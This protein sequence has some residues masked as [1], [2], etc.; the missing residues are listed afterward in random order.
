MAK[1]KIKTV[2]DEILEVAD[3]KINGT[4]PWDAQ[5]NNDASYSRVIKDGS[6]GLG[7]SFMEGWWDTKALDQLLYKV[8]SANLEQKILNNKK[9]LLQLFYE[10]FFNRQSKSKAFEVG[11]QHYDLGNDLYEAMLDKRMV[12]TCGYWKNAKNLDEAQEDK[13]DL[14]CRKLQLKKGMKV[15]DIGFGFGSFAKYAAQKYGVSVDGV[16]VSK[17]QL[18]YAQ[19]YCKGL[20]INLELKDYRDIEGKYDRIVSIGMFEA[21]GHKNFRTYM[22]VVHDHLT[23]DGLTLLHTIGTMDRKNVKDPWID[24]Y[25]FVNGELPNMFHVTNSI[26]KLFVM[27][28]WH[29]FGAYYDLT[30]M[31]WHKNFEKNWSKLSGKYDE[32]FHRMWNFYLL[33]CAA[34]FRAR[35]TQLWQIVL[36]KKGVKGGYES[37]R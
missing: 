21:V 2:I 13:L 36:S 28:D 17:E 37:I 34:L 27:E 3:I 4:R 22:K 5:V 12:Y 18:K 29:N 9:L 1:Q 31:A 10:K 6:L 19:E 11:E 7:E 24:K 32:R 15:L 30:L 33:S 14:I 25:I 20:P 8:F 26:D 35:K 16:T 23:D